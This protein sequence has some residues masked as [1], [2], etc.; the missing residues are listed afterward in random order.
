M[1]LGPDGVVTCTFN[2]PRRHRRPLLQGRKKKRS[3]VVYTR[4]AQKDAKKIVAA[5]LRQ[6]TERLLEILA[7]N[8]SQSQPRY[9]KL[10]GDL[11]GAW[12]RRINIQYR[13]VYEGLDRMKA[14][15]VLR[16]WTDYE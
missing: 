2:D 6:K 9:E 15:K 10:V 11:A 5:G 1:G 4:Q 7:R 8:P 14:V 16:M 13:L 12:S 3:Q